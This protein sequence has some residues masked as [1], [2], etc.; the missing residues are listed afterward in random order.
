MSLLQPSDFR[1]MEIP[2]KI[3]TTSCLSYQRATG[4]LT[5][6]LSLPSSLP[7]SSPD[8]PPDSFWNLKTHRSSCRD[9]WF[10][11]AHNQH[12]KHREAA[13]DTEMDETHED[14]TGKSRWL[15]DNTYHHEDF[16]LSVLRSMVATKGLQVTVIVPAKEV[17]TTIGGV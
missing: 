12:Q 13:K 3:P 8:S 7:D 14:D 9:N 11:R 6:P 5:P 2:T 4:L 1:K 15:R 17:A 16:A 10:C